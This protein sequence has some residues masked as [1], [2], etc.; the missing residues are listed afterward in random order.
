MDW[1]S[2]TLSRT[3]PPSNAQTGSPAAFPAM[4]QRACSMPLMA[5]LTTEPPGNRVVLYM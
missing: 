1:Y 3:R 2:R 5:E 4:S